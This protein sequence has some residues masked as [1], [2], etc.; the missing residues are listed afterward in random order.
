MVSTLR[1]TVVTFPRNPHMPASH[2]LV[3]QF[4]AGAGA[5]AAELVVIDEVDAARFL[6][7]T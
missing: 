1:R 6:L 3:M 2:D 4:G 5:G 7:S